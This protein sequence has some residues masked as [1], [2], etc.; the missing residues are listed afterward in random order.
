MK[1]FAVKDCALLVRMS[2]LPPAVNLRELRERV[3]VAR[4]SVLYHHFFETP[5]RHT[6]DDPFYRN[7]LAV[8]ASLRLRDP[9]L[10]ERLGI[11]D[12]YGFES[13]EALRASTLEIIDDRLSE[14]AIVPWAGPGEEFFFMEA[15]TVVFDTGERIRHPRDL[16]A[17]IQRMTSGSVY[18]HFLEARRREP[19]GLD[20]FTAW[21]SEGAEEF[22]NHRAALRSIDCSFNSLVQIREAL[23]RA[24]RIVE[25]AL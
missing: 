11:I 12:P 18:F 2:G 24:L 5:I 16:P 20:D 6:F 25:G 23:A 9:A 4:E 7:D 17:A 10:A 1:E 21:F 22:A 14:T 19:R 8:W 13:I 15:I 3:A